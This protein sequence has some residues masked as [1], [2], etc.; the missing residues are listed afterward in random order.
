MAN[1]SNVHISSNVLTINSAHIFTDNSARDTYFELHAA[2]KTL[3][4]FISVGDG[5]QQWDG[6]QWV[7]KT[8]VIRGPQGDQ[9]PQGLQGPEGTGVRATSVAGG[10]TVAVDVVESILA[11][12]NMVSSILERT[13]DNLFDITKL[14]PHTTFDA[15]GNTISTSGEIGTLDVIIQP[16]SEY[17]L[18]SGTWLINAAW[19]LDRDKA[20]I[21][22]ASI[23]AGIYQYTSPPDARYIRCQTNYSNTH[24]YA[25]K[26]IM[27]VLGSTLPAVF[28]TFSNV[29]RVRSAFLP[30]ARGNK[31]W[32]GKKYASCGDSRT[33]GSSSNIVVSVGPPVV[34]QY[35]NAYEDVATSYAW[36]YPLDIAYWTGA[37]LV[38]KAVSGAAWAYRAATPS[39]PT[40]LD[41]IQGNV[42]LGVTAIPADV[43]IITIQAGT[44]DRPVDANPGTN[45]VLWESGDLYDINTFK[46]S[47][48]ATLRYL[49]LNF[50]MVPVVI[51]VDCGGAN[52]T[53]NAAKN[54]AIIELATAW[55]FPV[56]KLYEQSL[57]PHDFDGSLTVPYYTDGLHESVYG[58]K[59]LGRVV[60]GEMARYLW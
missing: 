3:W 43:D 47:I 21:S 23:T 15:S 51:L 34:Y 53:A 16:D 46:G 57:T 20:P 2:E 24:E 54:A 19:W 22:N 9:G 31:D 60:A 55:R 6:S 40:I 1:P 25:S 48:R 12:G 36:S 52:P 59:V 5:F 38:Q 10:A 14:A 26:Q 37:T 7:D 4:L 30:G 13:S 42:G 32:A 33:A 27:V 39:I 11:P 56:L 28:V 41:Q 58:H 18:S 35:P 29:Y 8:P 17:S 49:K 44:N 50:Q 45:E